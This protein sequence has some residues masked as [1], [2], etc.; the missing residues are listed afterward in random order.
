MNVIKQIPNVMTLLNLLAGCFAIFFILQDKATY[1]IYL[2][3][4][5]L[6]LD[7]FDGFLARRFKSDSD[8]GIQLDSLADVVSFGVAPATIAVKILA[9]AT[10]TDLS[11]MDLGSSFAILWVYI[12]AMSA[13]L[14]LGKF[15]LK[16]SGVSDFLGIPTPPMATFFFGLLMIMQFGN[17]DMILWLKQKWVIITAVL[18]FT[19]MMNTNLI[20]FKF[21]P[22]KGF[23]L[24]PFVLVIAG[25]GI[26]LLFFSPVLAMSV[27][28]LA[29]TFLSII[30]NFV[31]I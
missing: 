3:F 17:M 15:N 7:F 13:A 21:R 19:V 29:Y 28:I 22:E 10:D 2:H 14:R 18:Y 23:F 5:S 1:A 24:N 20:H 25:I 27:T 31:K 11:A 16:T 12:L 26:A 6:I 9:F 4:A 30:A 8:L